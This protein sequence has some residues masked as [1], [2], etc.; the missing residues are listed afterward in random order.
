MQVLVKGVVIDCFTSQNTAKQYV[1]LVDMERRGQMKI[2]GDEPGVLSAL[3]QAEGTFTA[4]LDVSAAVYGFGK[5]SRQELTY[6]SVQLLA[7]G[8]GK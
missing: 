3:E 1:T 4:Q 6:H 7:N 2:K 5:E 8:N